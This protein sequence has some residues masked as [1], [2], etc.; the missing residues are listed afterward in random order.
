[1]QETLQS[2][3]Q[4]RDGEVS[5][6]E[7]MEGPTGRRV[8]PRDLKAGIAAETLVTGVCVIDVV[9]R[10]G[11]VTLWSASPCVGDCRRR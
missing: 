6:L 8:W 4:G 3:V 5:R 7:V 11:I 1:M 2:F 9:R 10:Q